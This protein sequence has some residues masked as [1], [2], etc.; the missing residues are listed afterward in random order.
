[1]AVRMENAAAQQRK[2]NYKMVGAPQ[3]PGYGNANGLAPV[4]K[5]H[6]QGHGQGHGPRGPPN[7]LSS[8]GPGG[9]H[10][11][12]YGSGRV[13]SATSPANTHSSS[14]S[15]TG[16]HSGTLSTSLSNHLGSSMGGDQLSK[17]NLYIRGLNQNTSDKD[18]VAMCQPYGNIIST[19]AIL[20]K[21]TNKCKGY[22][23]VDFESS[24][25]AEAAVK[26]LQ[27]K[28]IQAQMAKVGITLPRRPASQQEQDPTNLYIANLPLGYKENDVETL[29]SKYGQVISTR[30]LRDPSGQ[31][32]GVGFAR[33]D[34]KEKCEEIINIFNG[35][36]LQGAKDAL[37]VKFADGGNKKRSMYRPNQPM[38]RDGSEGPEHGGAISYEASGMAQN[39]LAGQ[40][41]LPTTFTHSYARQFGPV[42]GYSIPAAPW[43][44]SVHG[45][46]QYVMQPSPMT[47]VEMMPSDPN[48]VPYSS[49][50]PPLATQMQT[51]HIGTA[52]SYVSPYPYYPHSIIHTVIPDSEHTSNTASPDDSYQTYQQAPK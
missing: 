24:Q 4:N 35:Q 26:A 44:T 40:A 14:S 10:Q 30:I 16:S 8:P 29:L 7:N 18:L 32:K 38:W 47:Q 28:G 11:N 45:G 1:M 25:C 50:I 43:M 17:T 13:P 21:N 22:G 37:L 9:H 2:M 42:Q 48:S 39:G 5:G 52:P 49:M 12:Q 27:A 46:P 41:I 31:S 36:N 23:F 19:K 3:R 51:M 33:M 6:G 34:S 20:D 15:N